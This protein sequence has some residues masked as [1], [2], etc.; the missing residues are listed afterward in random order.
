[1]ILLIDKKE[2]EKNLKNI[3]N[4]KFRRYDNIEVIETG[5]DN[6]D[7]DLLID[8]YLKS[9]FRVNKEEDQL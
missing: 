4:R 5:L 8:L 1:L 2:G 7:L 6:D 3:M 9:E